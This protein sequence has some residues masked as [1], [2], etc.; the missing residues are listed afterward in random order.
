MSF[1]K[2]DSVFVRWG[3][4]ALRT[5]RLAESRPQS[6]AIPAFGIYGIG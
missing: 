2:I 6:N 5:L 3:S 4:I 1:K